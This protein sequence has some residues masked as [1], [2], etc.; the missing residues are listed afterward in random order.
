M[1]DS[2]FGSLAQKVYEHKYAWPGEEWPD[3]AWRV[4]S[5]VCGPVD[6]ELVQPV[7]EA[8]R[9][10]KLIPAGRFLY[11]AG[12]PYFQTSNCYLLRAE[13]SKEGWA[14]LAWK[15]YM[16]LMS[17]GGVGAVY[18]D[19]RPKGASVRGLGGTCTGPG[20]LME[21]INDIGHAAMQGGSRR[22]AIWA[23]LHWNHPDVGEFIRMK[24]WNEHYDKMKRE[25]FNAKAPM[26]F[27]NISVIFD[28]DFFKAYESGDEWAQEVYWNSIYHMRETGEP[29]FSV[30]IGENSGEN[31][32]NPCTEISSH[33]DSDICN[34][35]S[36]N[37]A[38]VEDVDEMASLCEIA[39]GFLIAATI[40]S[41]VPY[42]KVERIR[43]KNRRIG[44]GLMGM[45]EWLAMRNKP[46]APDDELAK[47][48]ETYESFTNLAAKEFAQD[49]DVSVPVKTR[50]IAPTGSISMLGET[51]SGLEP[52]FCAAYKRR[53]HKD[54]DWYAQYVVDG[55]AQRLINK[56]VDPNTIEDATS[57]AE[58]PAR[59]VNF[60]AWLQKYVDHGI[61][62]TINLPQPGSSEVTAEEFGN[63]VM[64][65]LPNLRGLTVYPDGARGGQPMNPVPL[66][67]AI[68]KEG[69]EFVENSE[70]QC[71]SGVC[72][73]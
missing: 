28:D 60:Q 42:E 69:V 12:R 50:A 70:D 65:E 72:Y 58:D 68:E 43:E 35:A 62:S 29:G 56:G 64:E 26:D 7:Y 57:L 34:L 41:H 38:Q 66:E 16:T 32:R 54:G 45:H 30:D 51:T 67:E 48:L 55:A 10:R 37:M 46:Y 40:V 24:D 73:T 2:P 61:S 52:I 13:D 17:G 47:Y 20:A 31:L 5:T 18:S 15:S 9:D 22:A 4:A 14:D 1:S 36:I 21:S 25:D 53:Y 23:G 39:T 63:A 11:A 44:L 59:R 8:I 6:E 49:W 3:T 27:T 71:I 33:D 19:I